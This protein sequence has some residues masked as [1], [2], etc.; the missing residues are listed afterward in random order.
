MVI[1]SL[2]HK[3]HSDARKWFLLLCLTEGRVQNMDPGPWTTP[4]DPVHGPPIFL[5]RKKEKI[6]LTKHYSQWRRFRTT[7]CVNVVANARN[8]IARVFTLFATEV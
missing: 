7:R 3:A 4:V 1:R 2:C 8:Y 6:T 5:T